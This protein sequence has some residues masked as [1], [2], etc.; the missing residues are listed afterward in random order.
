MNLSWAVRAHAGRPP[1]PTGTSRRAALLEALYQKAADIHQ[2]D[3]DK[4]TADLAST[5]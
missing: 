2:D 4:C 3:I 1:G 5:G